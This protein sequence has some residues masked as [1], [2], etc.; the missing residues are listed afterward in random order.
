MKEKNVYV[1]SY[2]CYCYG[3]CYGGVS[4]IFD[5]LEKAKNELKAIKQSEISDAEER[6]AVI[7]RIEESEDSL[8]VEA[9]GEVTTYSIREMQVQ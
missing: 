9:D 1:I 3:Y 8:K 2:N 7:D 4:S 5:S 6:G